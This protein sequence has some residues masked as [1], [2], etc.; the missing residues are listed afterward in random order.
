[1]TPSLL[2]SRFTR[3][4]NVLLAFSAFSA[5]QASEFI[6]KSGLRPWVDV[7]TPKDLYNVTSSRGDTWELVFSDE[8][9]VPGRDF[10]AGKDHVWTALELPDGVNAALEYYSIN[11]T[12]TVT[13]PDGRGVFQ[14]EAREEPNV[15][16][17]VFN[18]YT[19]P[20]SFQT[21]S[22]YYRAGM[23]QSWNK[24]CFQGGFVEV[25]AKL[26]GAVSASSGN[27]D[28]GNNK[29]R[30]ENIDYYPT[31]P[32]IW[33]MGNLGRALFTSSTNRMWPWSYD[34]C[35]DTSRTNQ[36]ISACDSNPGH[37]L[38]KNQG[39]G[40][41]EIDLLEGG[42]VDVSTSI[43]IAPGMPDKFR[44]ISPAGNEEGC[45]YGGNC[46]TVGANFPGIPTA[47]YEKRGYKTWYQGL[48]YAPNTACQSESSEKQDADAVIASVKKGITDNT[49]SS[50]NVCPASHDG[51]SDLSLIDG[52]GTKH[53]GVNE[54]GGCMPRINGY[55]GS[56]LCDPDNTFSKCS[57]PLREGNTKSNVMDSFNYQMD[58]LSANAG[59]PLAAYT[60][61]MKYQLE[62]VTGRNGYVRWMIEGVPIYEIPA[63][64][65]EN[66]PQDDANS[67]P[68]KLMLEEP[69]YV[70]FNV[71]LSTSWGS[72]PPNPGKP[73]RGDGTNSK[74]NKICDAFP[75]YL[76]IDY[77]RI[78]QDT[79]KNSSM[80]VG[81]DPASHPTK[82]WI[83]D[84]LEWYEDSKNKVI[85]VR[86]GAPCQSND[87]C[88]VSTVSVASIIT[89]K[90]KNNK[91]V[92]TQNSWAGPRCTTALS[93]SGTGSTKGFGPSIVVAVVFGGVIILLLAF[94]I[95][96]IIQKRNLRL[97]E[98]AYAYPKGAT[99]TDQQME[100]LAASQTRSAGGDKQPV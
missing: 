82:Q 29:A 91:C 86:G 36:R 76:K 73:C 53:W 84:H 8:F 22:M 95:Y 60:G 3:S 27:P 69:M 30:V 42:G 5:T 61:Y 44:M 75:M 16:F 20:P 74:T 54:A 4:M 98:Q 58:A 2:D 81:C 72:K 57:D 18:A 19:R 6:S 7:N 48:R 78:Y 24:F 10:S 1:M 87:D 93:D 90:C 38:N 100:D 46:K 50:L 77:I 12:S 35:D 15:T 33:F 80:S 52:K 62:W 79:S 13:E 92:C 17:T 85:E 37:G 34:V 28:L 63:E 65:V 49:C 51:N 45:F 23:V 83:D 96:K 55:M 94:V 25:S 97:L 32:G 11:M 67:N 99:A 71:A 88:T 59:L 56:Y 64:A 68:K 26:P 9:N 43:Q 89:G 14:I 40:A 66:P 41:P 70:I 39:R 21:Y 47:T 31:W